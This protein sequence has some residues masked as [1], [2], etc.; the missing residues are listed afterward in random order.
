[1]AFRSNLGQ[2]MD[3]ARKADLDADTL[4]R[5]AAHAKDDESCERI[6]ELFQACA[7]ARAAAETEMINE[8]RAL[9]RKRTERLKGK[10]S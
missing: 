1:M 2:I 5:A 7:D 8:L 10:K 3:R 9:A 4:L 6:I